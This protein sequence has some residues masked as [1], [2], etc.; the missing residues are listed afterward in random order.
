MPAEIVAIGSELT[1]GAKLDT[2]SQWLSQ[3]LAAVGVPVGFHTTIADDLAANV[4]ALRTAMARAD[5]ILITGGLG[6]TLDDLTRDALAEVL[7]VK[8]E[9]HEPSLE[10]I[11]SM[12]ARRNR[13]MPERN[14]VQAL[15]PVGSTPIPNP[16]GTAPGI[17]LEVPREGRPPC[18]IAAMPGVPSEM[19]AMF[20]E[21]VLP[22]VSAGAERRQ[23]IRNAR[24]NC[25]GVGESA[26]EELL[27]GLTVRGRDPEVGITVHE[28]TITLR[29]V[30]TGATVEEAEQ[31][32]QSTRAL[33]YERM[34]DYAFGE[35]DDEL[36]HVVVRGLDAAGASL[37]VVE[38]ATGGLLA[39]RLT[40]V[41]GSSASF[42]S[43][44][45]LPAGNGPGSSAL[46]GTMPEGT[47]QRDQAAW[48]A[49]RCREQSGADFAL[50]VSEASHSDDN[51]AKQSPPIVFVA[52]A[53]KMSVDVRELNVAGDPAI[54]K[55]RVAKSALNLLRLRLLRDRVISRNRV[56]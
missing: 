2:N 39:H 18:R 42:F 44:I 22:L 12:F 34:G 43:G 10:T 50:A 41:A 26:A 40:D 46:L 23:V 52:L 14:V 35:E 51:E 24:V 7:G 38:V 1:T 27:C 31:K 16:R 15:F 30:A 49:R 53:D 8:L 4:A 21:S 45:V 32:I 17:Y 5:I 20:R 28:A 25:F 37:A 48:L 11:R 47:A 55:S 9:L 3:E 36:E 19:K 33:I 56:G 6:P 13:E 29:I 54:L